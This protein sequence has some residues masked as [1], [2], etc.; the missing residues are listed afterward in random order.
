LIEGEAGSGKSALAANWAARYRAQHPD[1]F[2]FE[3]YVGATPTSANHL[4]LIS[5][6][7]GEIHERYS[8]SDSMPT[9]PG[10]IEE[11]FSAWLAKPQYETLVIVLDA[12]DALVD[13]SRDLVW[14]P[15]YL[16]PRV[17]II[18]TST[19]GAESDA[20]S[21]R[22]WSIVPVT[23]L[24][25]RQRSEIVTRYVSHNEMDL[26][27]SFLDQ[28]MT[29]GPSTNP[30]FLQTSLEEIRSR[31][32]TGSQDSVVEAY[33]NA[34]SVDEL[35]DR[36]LERVEAQTTHEA[37]TGVLS[38]IWASHSG[39]TADEITA[40]SQLPGPVV[41]SVLSS[42][43]IYLI[44]R[45]GTLAFF[46]AQLREAVRRRYLREPSTEAGVRRG[47]I[48]HMAGRAKSTRSLT[49]VMGQQLSLHE[50]EALARTFVDIE[51]FLLLEA[52]GD[53]VQLLLYFSELR[54][55]VDIAGGLFAAVDTV[56]SPPSLE[57]AELCE[58]V[59]GF[60]FDVGELRLAKEL[61]YRGLVVREALE[62]S[63]SD[64]TA[65]RIRLA[66][67]LVREGQHG[68]A[69]RVLLRILGAEELPDV[70]AQS[71][72]IGNEWLELEALECLGTLLIESRRTAE[73]EPV[74]ARALALAERLIDSPQHLSKYLGLAGAA[75]LGQR[76]F[77][78][79]RG[80]FARA[81]ALAERHLGPNHPVTIEST[82]NLGT[83]LYA[84]GDDDGA[85]RCFQ[86]AAAGWE[87]VF[88]PS[89]PD[90]AA[91]LGNL[92]LVHLRSGRFPECLEA[93]E[94]AVTIY[95]Q[96]LGD[97]H[98]STAT[99]LCNLASALRESGDLE[100]AE[101]VQRESLDAFLESY[102][103]DHGETV[104]SYLDLAIILARGGQLES[105]LEIY[106]AHLPRKSSLLGRNH[107]STERSRNMYR[108]ILEAAGH[109]AGHD[110]LLST[111]ERMP[112]EPDAA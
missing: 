87:Q 102:G 73:A 62:A 50:W 10:D 1:A 22:G 89:F 33:L 9:A 48:R 34:A 23:P 36:V 88:G 75:H 107:P 58:R 67:I 64:I 11:S 43:D 77:G 12:L 40:V 25:S 111:L 16:Q 81:A 35:M 72:R 79:A 109:D 20:L 19:P 8:L 42:I 53:R 13:H 7:I 112:D 80:L 90:V 84:Q 18:A 14:L 71:S 57:F 85:V 26:H 100:R 60:L 92:G 70:A 15:E 105:A 17:R 106:R 61:V 46:H 78:E 83:V 4:T 59:G 28:V 65:T 45:S 101:T 104:Q 86:R 54:K 66:R 56:E 99:M 29:A 2:L 98:P 38:I 74:C 37:A 91:A 96:A 52:E 47:I 6:I 69:E 103:P 30:L 55:H 108:M 51:S 82:N 94:R 110:E 39:L 32:R 21:D 76:S 49:E 31:A 97:R 95:R 93:L 63:P 27:P 68:E 3:H 5:R 41:Q 24:T 44:E